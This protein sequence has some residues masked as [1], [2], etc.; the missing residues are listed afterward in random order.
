MTKPAA[1]ETPCTKA[2]AR[3]LTRRIRD[4]VDQVWSLL[5]EAHD[6]KA[7][8]ALGYATWKAYVEAEFGMTKQRSYQLLDQGRVIA[9]IREAAGSESN[10]FDLSARDTAAIKADLPEVTDEIRTRVAAGVKPEKATADVLAAKRAEWDNRQAT[11]DSRQEQT[12]A[13][14]PE[15][16]RRAE[17]AKARNGA[18]QAAFPGNSQ[19]AIRGIEEAVVAERDELLEENAA[20]KADIAERDR[21]LAMFDDMA[22][23]FEKGG[24]EAVIATKD[25]QIRVLRRQVEDESADKATWAKRAEYWKRQAVALGFA[26]PNSQAAAD[27]GVDTDLAP[28]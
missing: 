10:A 7:W 4:G 1:T 9:S 6:R 12:R 24:F 5:T 11:N 28:F 21:R 17:E 22:V 26:P 18:S 8:S 25:E 19:R 23:Q 27:L 3:A 13:A 20:L 15:A 16:I 14:L 2:Q